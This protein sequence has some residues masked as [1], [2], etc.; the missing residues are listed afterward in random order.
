[1][2]LLTPCTLY[3]FF[4]NSSNPNAMNKTAK[5]VKPQLPDVVS[6]PYFINYN[7][8]YKIGPVKNLRSKYKKKI[9]SVD[10]SYADIIAV[11]FSSFNLKLSKY[12]LTWEDTY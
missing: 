8:K 3:S 4:S 10:V 1:M 9:H 12:R 2:I 5:H 11:I 6:L 7:A